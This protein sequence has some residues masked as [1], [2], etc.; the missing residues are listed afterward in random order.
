LAGRADNLLFDTPRLV[1][2]LEKLYRSM[3]R[4]YE[5]GQLPSPDLRNLDIYHEVGVQFAQRQ[6]PPLA[7]DDYV[8][9]YKGLLA[10]RDEVSPIH[11][12]N[13]L[14]RR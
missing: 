8:A 3:W 9:A 6:E 11:P 14:W 12:D 7:Y 1:E 10:L 2:G 5:N 4:D 13:R